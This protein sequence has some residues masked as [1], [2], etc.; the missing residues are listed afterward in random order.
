MD[1][2]SRRIRPRPRRDTKLNRHGRLNHR[3]Q[4]GKESNCVSP[5]AIVENGPHSG[6]GWPAVDFKQPLKT[7]TAIPLRA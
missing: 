2:L 6:A 1:P 5:S 7:S 4:H 3:E